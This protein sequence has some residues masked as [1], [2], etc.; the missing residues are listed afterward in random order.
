[1]AAFKSQELRDFN[2]I[3]PIKQIHQKHIIIVVSI[4]AISLLM[5]LTSFRH[6]LIHEAGVE[7]GILDLSEYSLDGQ[8][9]FD[10]RG[11][12]E[13]YWQQFLFPGQPGA[14]QT[15]ALS[16]Q[17]FIQVPGNWNT[18]ALNTQTHLA[19]GFGTYRLTLKLPEQAL[20]KPFA[21]R[22]HA[23]GTALTMWINSKRIFQA[24]V[25][26]KTEQTSQ[27]AYR[28]ALISWIPQQT[29]NEIIFHVSNFH[30]RS[31]GIWYAI[32][33]GEESLMR[34]ICERDV[35][36]NAF[37]V[38]ALLMIA[39][40]HLILF[41]IGKKEK[42][43]LY[44]ALL[45]STIIIRLLFTEDLLIHNWMANLSWEWLIRGEYL[46]LYLS[47]PFF[48]MF[49]IQLFVE[50]FAKALVIVFWSIPVIFSLGVLFTPP[51]FFTQYIRTFMGFMV[52]GM[53]YFSLVLMNCIRRKKEGA[54]ISFM[55]I[56]FFFLT[57]IND[58]LY[59]Q[60]LVPYGYY[61]PL[62]LFIL[63]LSQSSVLS[64]L[65]IREQ[66]LS[67]HFS[68][69]LE[70]QVS[71]RTHQ[72]QAAKLEAEKANQ[73]KSEF[74]AN[75]SHEIRTPMNSIIGF[76]ELLMDSDLNERQMDSLKKINR[77]ANSLLGIINDILDFSKIEAGKLEM[78]NIPFPLLKTLQELVALHEVKARDK[79]LTLQLMIDES[80]P[81]WVL[82]DSMRLGQVLNNLLSNA[83][84]FSDA[85]FVELHVTLAERSDDLCTIHFSV[86][87]EGIGMTEEQ[88]NKLFNAFSQVDT[89][90]TR[91]FGGTGLGLAI[92]Q[93]LV[94][95]MGSEIKVKSQPNH[96]STFFFTLP[97][98]AVKT[99]QIDA[100][101]VLDKTN[102]SEAQ[103]LNMKIHLLKTL[104]T[105]IRVLLAEDNA[106][107]QEIAVEN[108]K[109]V[110][111]Q[112]ILADNGQEAVE[113]LF[114]TEVDI[115]LMDLQ[116]PLMSGYEATQKIR[117]SGLYQHLPIIALS[118][119]A[120]KGVLEQCLEAG[121]NDYLSKPFHMD[122]LVE[123]LI[124][125]LPPR[126][127][128]SDEEI[129]EIEKTSVESTP[130]T[131][132]KNRETENLYGI[133]YQ[134]GMFNCGEDEGLYRTIL[135]EFKIT[136]K[137]DPENIVE[138]I[139]KQ[140]WEECLFQTH[141]LKGVAA[142]VGAQ[143]LSKILYELETAA[144]NKNDDQLHSLSEQVLEES[145]LIWQDLERL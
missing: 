122:A 27:P 12:Y 49:I 26:G 96:G 9:I 33:F 145:K 70:K 15:T 100:Q 94:Q 106:L 1:M 24:G 72:L 67:E 48:A 38:G 41:I 55:G 13:F 137:N 134:E 17:N 74:L 47:V 8:N 58:M 36:Y 54:L 89:T 40:Y 84:K 4:I 92:S 115:V 28:A 108:L 30:H 37:I 130:I 39:L 125:W 81:E 50:K 35:F 73:I 143:K 34:R 51:L 127:S 59:S 5:L 116:M 86:K 101:H 79:G 66:E 85:G 14:G 129:E 141:R 114:E 82:G 25:P 140:E 19:T 97:L 68:E 22:M 76:S 123:M 2:N 7:K 109:K 62:G 93:K 121:M 11:E 135:E 90:I 98:K 126:R 103:S 136:H 105:P 80:L 110:N 32:H 16:E 142:S 111:A 20:G 71:E 23:A 83:I 60:L 65:Y 144:K 64:H 57:V 78:E 46:S 43:S 63:V 99:S 77:S 3:K 56:V 75:M 113:K 69:Y 112:V 107:N 128:P 87:D 42:A 124:K 131:K 102:E 45:C 95:A 10:L 119:H 31:G 117:G 132:T 29:D 138:L 118:A 120:V 61:T 104:Y 139:K 52:V 88:L 21:F 53:I 44:F 133:N 91:K 6:H 18:F